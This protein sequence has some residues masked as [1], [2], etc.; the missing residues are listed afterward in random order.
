[1]PSLEEEILLDAENDAKAVKYIKNHLPQDLQDIF[2]EE[3]IYYFLDVIVEYYAESGLLE[4]EP[5]EEGFINIDLE[6]LAKHMA[7]KAKKDNIGTFLEEDLLF[8][9]QAEAEFEESFDME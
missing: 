1:M 3:I 5:D 9:A 7:Q 2:S 8:I 6:D 4:Q